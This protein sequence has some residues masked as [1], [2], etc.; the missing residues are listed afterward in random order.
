MAKAISL[1][2][3]YNRFEAFYDQDPMIRI[4][5]VHRAGNKLERNPRLR[6]ILYDLLQDKE[7]LVARYAAVTLAQSGDTRGIDYLLD[8]IRSTQGDE[9]KEL[10]NC[11]RN[12]SRF[13]FAV[14]LNERMLIES[15]A[16]AQDLAYRAVLESA[17]RLTSDDF[18][19]KAEEDPS[20]RET[21]LKII[22]SLDRI[23]GL[24]MRPDRLL[25]EGYVL[26]IPL[27]K[28]PGFIYCPARQLFLKYWDEAVTNRRYLQRGRQILFVVEV[29]HIEVSCL[30][31]L[32]DTEPC[33]PQSMLD[34]IA[35]PTWHSG[36]IPGMVAAVRDMP[37]G[38]H[39]LCV[40]GQSFRERY[41]AQRAS[42]G[43]FVLV[44]LETEIGRPQC[45][46]VPFLKLPV[47]TIRK[48]VSN[49]AS[50]NNLVVGKLMSVGE[51]SQRKPGLRRCVVITEAGKEV[52]MYIPD[53]REG[54]T[55]LL[56]V[57]PDCQGAGS[58]VCDACG[59]DGY[60]PCSGTFSCPKCRGT[61]DFEDTNKCV[62]CS[63]TGS[64]SGCNGAGRI[65]C[66]ACRG[67]GKVKCR[68]CGGK[69]EISVQCRKCGGSGRFASGECWSCDGS[70]EVTLECKGC[71]GSGKVDCFYCQ[72][73]AQITCSICHG[74]GQLDCRECATEGEIS[75]RQCRGHGFLLHTKVD[76]LPA[77]NPDMSSGFERAF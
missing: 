18:Y 32:E 33:D 19:A 55:V 36:L 2:D 67:R 4:A 11:L 57:C 28:Q 54:S 53:P 8:A 47:A 73:D 17:L 20:F 48:V 5:A 13:P 1:Q 21:F 35:N 59:G 77:R 75:C 9:R 12:C 14:L 74:A 34:E 65:K 76:C 56:E 49:F 25:D 30:Y 23:P 66:P 38:A 40:N 68:R 52:K 44:E 7:Q 10:D 37:P 29:G 24:Q 62:I 41:R 51:E 22:C 72:G 46:F 60:N 69:G 3:L 45:H 58:V 42:P 26:A 6:Q 31:V 70:G 39:V 64:T 27:G 43:Q 63:G 15:I 50:L 61:G 71:N 16:S